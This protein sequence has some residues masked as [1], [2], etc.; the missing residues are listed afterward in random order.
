MPPELV[1]EFDITV[2]PVGV[3]IN[4]KIYHD[5]VDITCQGFFDMFQDMD[6]KTTTTA[7]SP[8][9]F[10]GIF[11]NLAQS[12]DNILCIL[13]S[14]ALTATQESAY[15]ARRIFRSGEYNHLNIEIIDSRSSAGALGFMV[16]EAARAAK[17]GKSLE[18]IKQVVQDISSR[19]IYLSAIDTMK[20]LIR[21]GRALK[22]A[23][24]GDMMNIKPIIGFVDDSGYVEVIARVRG[25]ESA[26]PKMA[27][28]VKDYVDTRKPLHVNVHYS[29]CKEDGEQ[30][31]NL[32]TSKYKCCEVYLTEF[33]P[34]MVSTTGPMCG[35]AFY[36]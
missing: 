19:V 12:T 34:V 25:K 4:G 20:Y 28:M 5:N 21:N 9:E 27:D 1:Q 11:K 10:A 18:E 36:T 26:I 7:A 17:A 6:W 16:L 22:G 29:N 33:S 30:L 15:L 31:K 8:G 14:K 13:V 24:V 32:V 35:L 2:V 23:G 3:V